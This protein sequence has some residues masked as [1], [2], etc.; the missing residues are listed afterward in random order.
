[1]FYDLYEVVLAN[2]NKNKPSISSDSCN[3]FI[4]NKQLRNTYETL[5]KLLKN[6]FDTLSKHWGKASETL[7]KKKKHNETLVKN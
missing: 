5:I 6:S 7:I 4:T 3:D 1:M 2:F